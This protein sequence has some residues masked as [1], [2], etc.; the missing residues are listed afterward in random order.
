[1]VPKNM[2]T[3]A[4]LGLLNKGDSLVCRGKKNNR[5]KSFVTGLTLFIS[6]R[7]N[8]H[9]SKMRYGLHCT[10]EKIKIFEWQWPNGGYCE[11]VWTITFKKKRVEKYSNDVPLSLALI[12]AYTLYEQGHLQRF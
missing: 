1:M 4:V 7:V 12:S 2:S 6:T 8:F 3:L 10:L 9:D 5:R 11:L